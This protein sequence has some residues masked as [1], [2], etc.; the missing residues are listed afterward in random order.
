MEPKIT[1][2][3]GGTGLSVL[4]KGLKEITTNLS[5]IVAVSDDGGG[6]GILREDLGMLPPGDIRSC[7]ISL[8]NTEPI[9]EKLF[10]YRFE[11]GMLKGQSFGNLM[12]AAMVGISGSFEEAVNRVS[13]IFN[14]KGKVI[15]VTT[16]KIHLYGTLKNGA[17]IIGESKIPMESIK[18]NSQIER[19]ELTPHTPKATK[20]ALYN[21]LNSDVIILG[22]GSL[23]T[24]IIPNLLV[25]GIVNSINNSDAKVIMVS[26]VMTQPGE[27]DDYDLKDHIISINN[28]CE[29]LRIDYVIA[30]NEIIDEKTQEKYLNTKSVPILIK[31]SDRVFLKEKGIKLLEGKFFEV[32]KNYIRHDANEISKIILELTKSL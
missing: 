32:V 11:D 26:N 8:S 6:S 27:T 13:D 2:I 24:S 28:H 3:G 10:S 29:N 20:E 1:I 17:K 30:N 4:L 22:P 9:I 25:E 12:I 31:D 23:Y 21:I 16:E 19:I 14:I 18:Q 7:I 15:P 5:A